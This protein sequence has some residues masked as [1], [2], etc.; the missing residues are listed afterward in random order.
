MKSLWDCQVEAVA[1]CVL[2]AHRDGLRGRKLREEVARLAEE[3]NL[4]TATLERGLARG[5]RR[6]RAE[7]RGDFHGRPRVPHS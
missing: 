1:E 5:V 4:S 6:A 7:A 3:H 2:L